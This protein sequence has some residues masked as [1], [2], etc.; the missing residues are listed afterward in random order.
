MKLGM[1]VQALITELQS[2]PPHFP[3]RLAFFDIEISREDGDFHLRM[4]ASDAVALTNVSRQGGF[5]LL[6]SN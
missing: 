3:I 4:D 6:E 2:M 1:T 5:I